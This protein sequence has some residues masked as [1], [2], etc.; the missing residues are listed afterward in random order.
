MS[1]TMEDE[2]EEIEALLPWFVT[3]KLA[4]AER[5][6]IERYLAAHPDV[7]RQVALAREESAETIAGAESFGVPSRTSFDR[8]MAQIGQDERARAGLMQ[9]FTPYLERIADWIGGFSRV[10]LGGLAVAAALLLAVQAVTVTYLMTGGG[11]TY[12][13]ASGPSDIAPERGTFAL[14]SFKP[15]ATV[16]EITAMLAEL[17]AQ[18]VDGPK[19][20]GLW[21]VRLAAEPLPVAD[22]Q[23][24]IETL[25]AKSTVV[26]FVSLTQ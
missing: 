3:G 10:Q 18:V 13:T 26:G 7:A 23:A 16:Q 6:R 24:R 5:A 19:A 2:R 9:R 15:T 20:G 12:Q 21:R 4:E 11:V 1:T 14:V 8:L 17:G 25:R 22:A